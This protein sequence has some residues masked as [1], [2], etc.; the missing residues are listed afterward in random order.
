M[1]RAI[2]KRK[3]RP[4]GWG[5]GE[6]PSIA[7]RKRQLQRLIMFGAFTVLVATVTG[8]RL[9]G[10]PLDRFDINAETVASQTIQAAFA[11]DSEDL[12]ATREA[13]E[14]AAAERPAMYS[15]DRERVTNQILTLQQRINTLKDRRV[16]IETAILDA[17]KSST[18]A[19]SVE[20]VVSGVLD[21][22]VAKWK[23]DP[24]FEGYPDATYLKTWIQPNLDTLPRRNFEEKPKSTEGGAD[25]ARA[26]K[27]LTE[28]P[29]EGMQF[30][31]VDA[32]TR[33]SLEGLQH[34]LTLG[35]LQ[36]AAD[37]G[38]R[39][40]ITRAE[41]VGN[42]PVK[43]EVAVTDVLR[44]DSARTRL[45]KQI[46]TLADQFEQRETE[47]IINW[48]GLVT[49]AFEMA[50]AGV[51]DTLVYDQVLTEG[52]RQL[53]RGNTPPVRRR[54][55]VNQILQEEGYA[56]NEQSRHDVRAYWTIL[57][58][59]S[60]S[61]QGILSPMLANAIIVGLLLAALWRSM[62]VLTDRRAANYT[63]L[64]TA[65]LIICGTLLLGRIVMYFEPSGYLVPLTA[66]AML[67][68]I[69]TNPRLASMTTLIMAVLLSVQYGQ[70]WRLFIVSGA[71][72][73]ASILSL[74]TVRRRT[75]MARA[76]MHATVIGLVAAIAMALSSGR[77]FSFVALQETLRGMMII[78]LNGIICL[79]VVPG[80]LS[81]LERLFG[82]TTDIQ[83]LEYSDLNNPLLSRLAI[84]VP[85]TYAHSLAMGQLAEAAADAIGANGLMARVSAYY[86]DI[87]KLRRPEYF[88]EN[89]T[90]Y[91]IH[92]ELSP[93]LSARAI[94]SHVTEGVEIAR[95]YHLPQP[96]IRGILEHHG[97]MLI[98]FFYQ[99]AVSQ[100]KHGDVRE[101]DFR[102]PGPKPQSPETAILMICDG[103]E[104][105]VRTIKNPNEER[106]REFVA[107]IIRDRASDRQF[108][109]CDLTLK[110]LDVIGDVLA[111]RI[112]T[113]M[114]ARIAYPE[115]PAPKDA[116][117]V[118]H[119]KGARE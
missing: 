117:N 52:E 10:D 22:V 23:A 86:H 38:Q 1:N 46:E 14:Q 31:N 112:M 7:Y 8:F 28:T 60:R 56:W 62:P 18:S 73:Y 33:L 89:Q 6:S 54:I 95:E 58:S 108:D 114:H 76:A 71:M 81:P 63:A 11:F 57:E 67:M 2:T 102:Y 104:S 26:V 115:R 92:E 116:S 64:N 55:E 53:A 101:E 35:V 90:G 82:I 87:G 48:D 44:P 20:E 5:G 69:L 45:R 77:L 65:L 36:Q 103:V 19:Q 93:R 91:N 12:E 17:L 74:Y 83:L 78:G 97:T 59:G 50:K 3:G 80:L 85:A 39:V 118:I 88:S 68:T 16:E 25:A 75:D 105:G 107:K 100:S 84:E 43:D 37:A 99:Q 40:V 42:I 110:K 96:I 70:N 51:I 49:A 72:A 111:R 98:S 109:E 94:A 66:G 47:R 9:L 61:A 27:S 13:R 79:F 113:G 4:G 24:L 41:V 119:I 30:A 34:V 15:V 29:A 32:L 21:T 106:I